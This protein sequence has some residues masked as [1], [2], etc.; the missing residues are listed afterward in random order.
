[1]SASAVG[2]ILG[3]QQNDIKKI[4]DEFALKESELQQSLDNMDETTGGVQHKQRMI[5]MLKKQVEHKE[6]ALEEKRAEIKR[7]NAALAE[8]GGR[9]TE[10]KGTEEEFRNRLGELVAYEE[11]HADKKAVDKLQKLVVINDELKQKEQEFKKG[12]KRELAEIEEE[13]VKLKAS[14]NVG[15]EGEESDSRMQTKIGEQYEAAKA[16][17][18]AVRLKVAKRNREISSL[19]RRL[20]EL[21]SRV[22]LSQYQKR[23]VELYNQSR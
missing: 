16:K 4:A 11:N 12:C 18:H 21:P 9:F 22:E 1:M 20:D 23:F 15:Q 10:L 2:Q 7:V 19:Q 3:F 6:K 8:L 13:L 5:N 17:M 14:L